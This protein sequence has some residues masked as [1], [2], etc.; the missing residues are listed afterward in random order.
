MIP[1]I[2]PGT[3]KRVSFI[4]ACSELGVSRDKILELTEGMIGKTDEEKEQIA[5]QLEMQIRAEYAKN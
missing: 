5:E 4:D 3:E 2:R 1:G